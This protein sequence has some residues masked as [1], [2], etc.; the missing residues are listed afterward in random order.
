[1]VVMDIDNGEI[2]GMI[3]SPSYDSNIFI[4]H[5]KQNQLSGLFSDS[6][7]PLLN[8][9]IQGVFPPGS[10]FK[11]PV[12]V[13]ALNSQKI[14]P[15]TTFICEG[16]YQI[17]GRKFRCTHSHGPQ[18][19]IK[20]LAHSCNVY[21]YHVGLKLGV[22]GMNQYARQLGLGGLTYIDLPY[23]EH[24]YIP[25]QRHRFQRGKRQWYAGDTLNFSVGQG[26]VL[27]T[28]I[29]AVR[30]IATVANDGIEVQPHVI[31]LI[32]GVPLEQYHSKRD[33]K[34]DPQVLKIIQK[35]LRAAVTDDF[36]TA[37]ELDID[38]LYV[39]G[40]TG[41]AQTSGEKE[42]HAWFIGYVKNAKKN[43]A[44]CVFLEHGGSSQN[45]CL[46][47]KQFLLSMK[48]KELL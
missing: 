48:E 25:T 41:T 39:A 19:L 23:E 16:F 21:Y 40:K 15:E 37:R 18:N 29:Q 33:T 20:S 5:N 2:L 45:A 43:I 30:M 26:D 27:V 46:V 9:A 34:I 44:F 13:G 32:G 17:G 35:G 10:I 22:D 12:A 8:R 6:S 42:D 24:G 28:P 11:I 3:S 47:S 38:Q 7:A 31:K 36:G 1:M 4:D 14:T